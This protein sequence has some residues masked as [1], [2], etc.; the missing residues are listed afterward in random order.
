MQIKEVEEQ[1]GLTAKSIRLYE[2]K[3]LFFVRRNE[4]G[5]RD[6]TEQDVKILKEIKLL[7]YLD[8]SLVEIQELLQDDEQTFV[9]KLSCK[10]EEYENSIDDIKMKLNVIG[11][12]KKNFCFKEELSEEYENIISS[13]KFIND[14]EDSFSIRSISEFIGISFMCITPIILLICGLIEENW[15][16]VKWFV[17]ISA[18]AVIILTKNWSEYIRQKREQ[19]KKT[20]EANKKIWVDIAG[21]IMFVILLFAIIFTSMIFQE[22][23]FAPEDYLFSVFS[24]G[25]FTC[26]IAVIGIPGLV[27]LFILIDKIKSKKKDVQDEMTEEIKVWKIVFVQIFKY[28]FPLLW[29]GMIL[30]CISNVTYITKDRIIINRAFQGKQIYTYEDV[31]GINTGFHVDNSGIDAEFYYKIKLDDKWIELTDTGMYSDIYIDADTFVEIEDFDRTVMKYNPQKTGTTD[32]YDKCSLDKK[33]VDRAVA[34]I[35]NR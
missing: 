13:I 18:I 4:N 35:G 21:V 30:I 34:I 27:I 20:K 10:E 15:A 1:T 26:L 23:V 32:G 17:P 28:I 33:Y 22:A 11:L 8:F 12:L 3:G 16:I 19:P 9:S 2:A 7:R 6:Y 14:I 5:Y 24:D 31:S 29:I 25:A